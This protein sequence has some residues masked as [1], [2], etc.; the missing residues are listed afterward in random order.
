MRRL[1]HFFLLLQ[2]KKLEHFNYCINRRSFNLISQLPKCDDC[3]VQ[4]KINFF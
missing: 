1:L 2:P 3:V 4:K